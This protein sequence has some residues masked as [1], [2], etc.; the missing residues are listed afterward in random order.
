MCWSW[1]T[2]QFSYTHKLSREWLI[3]ETSNFVYFFVTPCVVLTLHPC[4]GAFYN[5]TWVKPLWIS[6]RQETMGFWE[7]SGI[8]WTICKQSAPGWRQITITIFSQATCSSRHPTNIVSLST[9]GTVHC[10]S[11]IEDTCLVGNFAKC[12]L[13]LKSLLLLHPAVNLQ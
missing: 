7:C 5:T 8:S 2:T 3:P 10:E 11:K 1:S 6:V 13:M 4:I 12:S 9:E